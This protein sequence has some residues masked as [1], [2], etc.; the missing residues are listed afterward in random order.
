MCEAFDY[1]KGKGTKT[2][3]KCGAKERSSSR[4]ARVRSTV[5][6]HA[7]QHTLERMNPILR[8]TRSR[9]SMRPLGVPLALSSAKTASTL[10]LFT[11]ERRQLE[12]PATDH[13]VG[14]ARSTCSQA[15]VKE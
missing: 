8:L 3:G 12:T 14:F 6:E 13:A 11:R 2:K 4:R 7:L 9:K 15:C 1:K 10:E 5:H